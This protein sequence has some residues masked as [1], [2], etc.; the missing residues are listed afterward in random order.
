MTNLARFH[1]RVRE[2]GVDHTDIFFKRYNW[3]QD[4]EVSTAHTL[5]YDPEDAWNLDDQRM[6]EERKLLLVGIYGEAVVTVKVDESTIIRGVLQ[7]SE[8]LS[9][10]A[11][12]PHAVSPPLNA[13]ANRAS[14]IALASSQDNRSILTRPVAAMD[15]ATDYE[16]Y[17]G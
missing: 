13:S 5:H 9:I 15:H 17:N 3:L 10:P 2:I 12:M 8:S 6:H 4:R 11:T 14:A 16:I 7:Q 1:D